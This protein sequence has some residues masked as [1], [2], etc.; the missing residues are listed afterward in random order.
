MI[1]RC[2]ED[3]STFRPAVG[4]IAG[5]IRVRKCDEAGVDIAVAV[6]VEVQSNVCCGF[7]ILEDSL[8]CGHMAGEGTRIASAES[9]DC[10]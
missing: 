2:E 7:E 6:A 1:V 9:S 4:A 10:I 5:P 3:V 8:C